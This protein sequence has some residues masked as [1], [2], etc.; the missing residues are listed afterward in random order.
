MC[1]MLHN[2]IIVAFICFLCALHEL[3][4]LCE[5]PE[6]QHFRATAVMTL[7]RWVE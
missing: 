2:M 5:L 3:W 1:A 6:F 4:T 7:W